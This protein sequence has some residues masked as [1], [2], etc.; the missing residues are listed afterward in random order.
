MS[1]L[2][3]VRRCF[4]SRREAEELLEL[5]WGVIANAGWPQDGAGDRSVP[6][7]TPG[8]GDAAVRWRDRYFRW[9]S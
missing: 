5:A 2:A 1:L 7:R 3:R 6:G 4:R 9:L 8:W